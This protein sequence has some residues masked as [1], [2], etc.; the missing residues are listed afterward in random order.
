MDEMHISVQSTENTK[1][2]QLMQQLQT[3][4]KGLSNDEVQK[5]LTRFGLFRSYTDQL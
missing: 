4:F 5:R 3:S 1:I 2:D